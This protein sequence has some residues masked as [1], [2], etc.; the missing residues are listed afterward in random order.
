MGVFLVEYS[1]LLFY[2]ESI[3]GVE[4]ENIF[5]PVKKSTFAI[6]TTSFFINIFYYFCIH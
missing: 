4:N 1:H 5:W 3:F 6:G 2:K